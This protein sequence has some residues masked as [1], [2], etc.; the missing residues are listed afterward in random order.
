M[1][2]RSTVTRFLATDWPP[3]V[4]TDAFSCK[5]LCSLKS[6]LAP[7]P[8]IDWEQHTPLNVGVTFVFFLALS[9]VGPLIA[10]LSSTPHHSMTSAVSNSSPRSAHNFET[11]DVR[12]DF[13]PPLSQSLSFAVPDGWAYETRSAIVRSHPCSVHIPPSIQVQEH[14]ILRL[15]VVDAL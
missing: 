4:E 14:L 1:V 11:F 8:K 9:C 2:S 7:P 6:D 3:T 5:H 10:L 13:S 12:C 15:I